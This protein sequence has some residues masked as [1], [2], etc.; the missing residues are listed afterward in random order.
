M[1]FDPAEIAR[2]LFEH[3]RKLRKLVETQRPEI[4]DALLEIAR[5]LEA[6]ATALEAD[7]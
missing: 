4:G 7:R 5:E 3:A 6:K 1:V 2:F